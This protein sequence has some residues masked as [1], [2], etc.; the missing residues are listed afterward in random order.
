M[1]KKKNKYKKIGNYAFIIELKKDAIIESCIKGYKD[2]FSNVCILKLK[3][4]KGSNYNIYNY[5]KKIL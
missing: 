2:M 3:K 1:A 4:I 5:L